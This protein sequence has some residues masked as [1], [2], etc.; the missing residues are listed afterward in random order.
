MIEDVLAD[1]NAQLHRSLRNH[2]FCCEYL[3]AHLRRYKNVSE[4][5]RKKRIAIALQNIAAAYGIDL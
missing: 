2:K 5:R 1:V 3:R 4:A